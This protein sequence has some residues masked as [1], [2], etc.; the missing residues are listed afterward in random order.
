MTDNGEFAAQPVDERRC[1]ALQLAAVAILRRAD[2]TP[3]ER[4]W[5]REVFDLTTALTEARAN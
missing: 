3:L 2:V 5:A 4:R 1:A